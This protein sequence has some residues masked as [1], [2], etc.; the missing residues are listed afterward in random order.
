MVTILASLL[1][2]VT[3]TSQSTATLAWDANTEADINAY[4]VQTATTPN[5]PYGG[6]TWV[7]S[8]TITAVVQNLTPGQTYYFVVRAVNASGLYSGFSN[9][10]SV[11]MPTGP[12]SD[13]CAPVTGRYAVSVFPTN[14]LRTGS[15]GPGS[16][17]R[18]D[19]QLA[20]PNSPIGLIMIAA[21]GIVL[22]SQDGA[23]LTRSGS[24]WFTMPP[25]GSYDLTLTATNKQGCTKTVSFGQL[26]VP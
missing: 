16:N 17:T 15:K 20:S 6:D 3:V 22:S 14:L 2:S 9:E 5:G 12:G 7:N 13:L 1:L 4:L 11:T 23:N 10:V 19:Y 24:Q 25:S 26:N 18:F 21:G 8:S